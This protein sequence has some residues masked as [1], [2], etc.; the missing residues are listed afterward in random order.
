MSLLS[1]PTFWYYLINFLIGGIMSDKKQFKEG[2]LYFCLQ[3]KV[4]WLVFCQPDLSWSHLGRENLNWANAF[5]VSCQP[6]KL[7]PAQF[8]SCPWC[9]ILATESKLKHKEYTVHYR[10]QRRKT[11]VTWLPQLNQETERDECISLVVFSFWFHLGP[12]IGMVKV[13]RAWFF[14]SQLD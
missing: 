14:T 5:L 7:P 3:F 8:A 2:E 4:C 9:F 10:H 6:H 11:L 1:I 12:S 13:H